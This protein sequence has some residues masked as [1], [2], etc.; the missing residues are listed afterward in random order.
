M[1]QYHGACVLKDTL[2]QACQLAVCLTPNVAVQRS[3][4]ETGILGGCPGFESLPGERLSC[5]NF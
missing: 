3:L 2:K 4:F 5:F 1:E